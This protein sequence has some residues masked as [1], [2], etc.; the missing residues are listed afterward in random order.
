MLVAE[1]LV[2]VNRNGSGKVKEGPWIGRCTGFVTAS[3]KDPQVD[4]M[5][6]IREAH[7][8]GARDWS[9]E[10]RRQHCNSLEY[11]D[12]L[13]AV[14]SSANASR[15]KRDPS[16]W[17]PP[18]GGYWC[19]YLDDRVAIKRKRGLSMDREDMRRS[20]GAGRYAASTGCETR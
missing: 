12:H 10:K 20:S 7:E 4:H 14:W 1:S 15:G 9:E 16:E 13:I 11:D 8:S 3:P 6:P 18:N 2:P 5:A 19:E 17:L